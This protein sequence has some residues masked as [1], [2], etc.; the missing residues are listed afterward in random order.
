MALWVKSQHRL[1]AIRKASATALA[2]AVI[3]RTDCR[4]SDVQVD[5]FLFEPGTDAYLGRLC[6]FA[7]C[8]KGKR[9][10]LAPGCGAIAFNRVM[11]GCFTA[12]A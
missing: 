6:R 4:V 8:P 7:Q 2:H 9:E 1:R 3:E 5:A 11:T 10:C 12:R